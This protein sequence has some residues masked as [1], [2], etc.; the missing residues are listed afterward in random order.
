[1]A[2]H[3]SR[4]LIHDGRSSTPARHSAL[5][6]LTMSRLDMAARSAAGGSRPQMG[7]VMRRLEEVAAVLGAF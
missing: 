3:R 7:A 1:M 6:Y 5:V 2:A 4:A